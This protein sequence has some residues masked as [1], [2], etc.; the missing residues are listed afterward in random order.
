MHY[1]NN[2][3]LKDLE[4]NFDI[5]PEQLERFDAYLADALDASEKAAFEAQL[6][7]DPDL[8]AQFNDFREMVLGIEQ[9]VL[10]K[11]LDNFHQEM[12]A[13]DNPPARKI[14][15]FPVVRY[16]AAACVGLLIISIGWMLF[17]RHLRHL[18]DRHQSVLIA[19]VI[20]QSLIP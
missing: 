9:A 5:S 18:P 8:Q 10:S 3:N 19:Q 2:Q 11:Q 14:Y 6:E 20:C 17:R 7:K 12:E 16:L 15:Q 4:S 13:I 1:P